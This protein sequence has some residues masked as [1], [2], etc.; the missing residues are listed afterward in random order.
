V[1]ASSGASLVGMH[2]SR[3]QL[4]R[5]ALALGVHPKDAKTAPKLLALTLAAADAR[6][7]AEGGRVE[8]TQPAPPPLPGA[9]VGPE[10]DDPC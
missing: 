3:D 7:K 4:E 5:I 9:D 1:T 8:E 2:V 10:P 6:V